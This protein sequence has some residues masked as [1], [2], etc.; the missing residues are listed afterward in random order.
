MMELVSLH[1]QRGKNVYKK[2]THSVPHL[3]FHYFSFSFLPILF[4]I[5]IMRINRVAF[6]LNLLTEVE[7]FLNLI[8]FNSTSFNK[9][10]QL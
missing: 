4:S 8:H 3:H 7:S 1:R 10:V 6:F 2:S 5:R 9:Y